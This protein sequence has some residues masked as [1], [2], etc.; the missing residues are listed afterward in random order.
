MLPNPLHTRQLFSA[1][2]QPVEA[3]TYPTRA[4]AAGQQNGSAIDNNCTTINVATYNI[5]DDQNSNLEAAPRACEKMRID[6]SV[7]TE[8]KLSTNRYTRSA[9]GYTVY[10]TKTTHI[11]QGRITLIFTNNSLYFQIEAQQRHGLNIISCII[12]T[13]KRQ[14]PI[15]GAYIPPGDTTTLTYI[16]EASNPILASKIL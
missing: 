9:Y 16:S 14:H 15:I 1:G 11:N 6:V 12:V 13:E 10:A 2:A 7:L 3:R 5:Q 8:T 4:A